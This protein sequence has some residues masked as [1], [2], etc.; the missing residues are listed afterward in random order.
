VAKKGSQFELATQDRG[1]GAAPLMESIW[2]IGGI[3]VRLVLRR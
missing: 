2:Q 1:R 3:S